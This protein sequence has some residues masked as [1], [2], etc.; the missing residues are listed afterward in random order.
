MKFVD[1]TGLGTLWSKIKS[2]I[3]TETNKYLP[4]D[5][6]G[7]VKTKVGLLENYVTTYSGTGV[8]AKSISILAGNAKAVQIEYKG[9]NIY[10][11]SIVANDNDGRYKFDLNKL[12][13]DGYL[14]KI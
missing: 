7:D 1:G 12:I 6:G 5:G 13:E 8:N 10:F 4:L 14:V 11:K 9:D 2:L 3:T